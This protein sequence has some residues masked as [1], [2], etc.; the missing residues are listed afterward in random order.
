MTSRIEKSLS[1][2]AEKMAASDRALDAMT[3]APPAE[4][5]LATVRIDG[6]P[7]LV[8][9]VAADTVSTAAA[10]LR[11]MHRDEEFDAPRVS[12]FGKPA[13][14]TVIDA[15]YVVVK[16]ADEPGAP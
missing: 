11:A 1:R 2:I 16:S 7:G 6:L 3:K 12:P 15:D 10:R 5:R 9:A 8:A 14:D 4:S 13:S